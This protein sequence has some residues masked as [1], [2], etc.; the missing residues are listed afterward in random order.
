MYMLDTN[1]CIFTLKHLPKVLGAIQNKKEAGLAISS[2]TLAELEFGIC[3]SLS[4]EKNRNALIAF[5]PTVDVLQFGESA[6]I[7]YGRIR[8]NLKKRGCITG[9][10]DTLIAAHAKS[11]QLVLVT[12]NTGEFKR[13]DGLNLEDWSV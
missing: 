1:T 3:N 9:L 6:A 7:E 12:N 13:I 2:I 8:A 11:A 5:L 10:M 4:V